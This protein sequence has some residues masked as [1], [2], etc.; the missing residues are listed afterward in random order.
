MATATQ[1]PTRATRRTAD[2]I[3]V[4]VRHATRKDVGAFAELYRLYHPVLFGYVHSR[5]NQREEAEDLTSAIF[6]KAFAAIGRYQPSPAQFSTWLHTIARNALIDN[7]RKRKPQV[8]PHGD[9][10]LLNATDPRG[11]PE[12][13]TIAQ[14]LRRLLYAAI[15][16]LTDDQRQV[17][18]LRFFFNL[19]VTEV[20][21]MMGKSEGAVKALQS[22]AL[23]RLQ[24]SLAPDVAAG[25]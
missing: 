23:E 14:D 5:L 7:Y 4:L 10:E 17:V 18:G 20:A 3:R 21:R 25:W 22:R 16:E 24:R 8:E 12:E 2:E 19:P 15:L 11:G 13:E 9:K 1:T 6:E